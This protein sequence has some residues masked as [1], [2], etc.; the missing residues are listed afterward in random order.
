MF[1]HLII[2]SFRKENLV[3]KFQRKRQFSM[4]II[5]SKSSVPCIPEVSLVAYG[6]FLVAGD[7]KV[8]SKDFEDVLL[9]VKGFK[10]FLNEIDF[11]PNGKLS[12]PPSSVVLVYSS[13]LKRRR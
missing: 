3:H 10:N 5:L 11:V 13:F 7:Q 1:L 4:C 9:F 8:S 12:L 2:G 6:H